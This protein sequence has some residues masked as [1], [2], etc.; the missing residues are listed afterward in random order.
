M[1]HPLPADAAEVHALGKACSNWGR[2]GADDERGTL[3]LIGPDE[4]LAACALPVSGEIVSCAIPFDADGPVPETSRRHNPRHTM[5]RTGNEPSSQQPGGFRSADADLS[6]SVHG[7]TQ[8][9]ALAHVHYDGL[10]YNGRPSSL[11][12]DQGAGACG[13]ERLRAGVLG[14]G[15]LLDVPLL[16]DVPWLAD[17]VAIQPDELT[18]C[19]EAQ[20]VDIRAGD[21]LLVRTGRMA[22]VHAEGSWGGTY[23][24]G[25]TPGLSIRCVAWLR[26]HN[27]AAVASD[28]VCVEVMP[29]EVSDCFMPLHMVCI[30]DM[31]LLLGEIFDLEALAKA[32]ARNRRYEFLFTAPPL[33]ITG[34]VG[35][36]INPLA[37]L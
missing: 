11:I 3:N 2:W 20:G 37:V 25:P 15:V 22:R 16:H 28:T 31:G 29:N 32:C 36:P 27:V 14:R 21:I 7:A 5:A 10:L 13:I 34:G 17:G 4:V 26:E 1:K 6:M 8:W 18:A 9:D 23:G 33:P 30:R 19:A 35:S 24:T 12:T